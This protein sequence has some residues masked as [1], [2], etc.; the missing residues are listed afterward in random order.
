MSPRSKG[1]LGLLDM[2]RSWY[3]LLFL[4][5]G[6]RGGAKAASLAALDARAPTI[7]TEA[8]AV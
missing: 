6:P 1:R 8:E 7:N 4:P 5:R 3:L 2:P